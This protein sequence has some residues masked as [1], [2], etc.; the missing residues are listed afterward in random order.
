MNLQECYSRVT[1]PFGAGG[2][3]YDPQSG[4]GGADYPS[5]AGD[6]VLAYADGVIGFVGSREWGGGL[7]GMKMSS[8]EYAGWAHL[9]PIN[10][11]EDQKV[12]KG[13]IIGYTAGW[14]D[15]HGSSWTGPHIHTTR[16]ASS[17][18]A[19]ATGIR[20]LI[21][22]APGIAAA[23]KNSASP[24]KGVKVKHYHY[25][26][27]TAR[28]KGRTLSPGHNLYLHTELNKPN[29]NASNVV[30]GVGPY[31][32]TPHIYATGEPGEGV[33]LCLIWSN[34]PSGKS[35]SSAHYTERLTFNKDGVLAASREYKRT[36]S[37]GYSVYLRVIAEKSNTKPVT[38]T[39]LDCDSYLFV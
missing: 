5:S 20:P 4:H 37:A 19:A 16:S 36:V 38:I 9:D 28:S 21:D 24:S 17:S 1:N 18:A 33:E 7:V 10:V 2:P 25:Q 26:D 12:S 31:S 35:P 8:G 6:P 15:N 29:S 34:D 27:P 39:L 22:P 23:I 13:D 11:V 3:W 14:G 32:I 30:G